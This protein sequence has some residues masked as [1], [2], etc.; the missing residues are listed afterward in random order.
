MKIQKISDTGLLRS[1]IVL[2]KRVLAFN[3]APSPPI[4]QA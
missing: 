4:K 3:D 1:G 2:T